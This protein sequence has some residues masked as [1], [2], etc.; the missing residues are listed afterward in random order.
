MFKNPFKKTLL[1]K[2]KEKLILLY[3]VFK[4]S[5]IDMIKQDGVEHSGYIAFLCLL[6][7]F[8]AVI[9]G[10]AIAGLVGG[11]E[12]GTSAI[13][14]FMSNV[15]ENMATSLKPIITE[16]I[17][18]PSQSILSIAFAGIIWTA[19]S[20]I[21]G[22]R[23]ILNRA[24]RVSS[25]PTYILR[26]LLSILHFLFFIAAIM[27]TIFAFVLIPILWGKINEILGLG[28][29]IN[30]SFLNNRYLILSLVLLLITSMAYYVIPNIKLKWKFILP[31]AFTTVI[32]WLISGKIFGIYLA[33]FSQFNLI[34]GSLGGIVIS[35]I[36]F[37]IMSMIFVWGAEFNYQFGTTFS[38]K[39]FVEK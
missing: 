38:K 8:P 16:I 3:K 13:N 39:S 29:T 6:S 5:T 20:E 31:G 22:L 17:S 11:S 27:A 35:L 14:A 37:Y 1:E 26:R 19:S 12:L 25:P 4:N 24:Y 36:F 32:G 15:P 34:Y 18:G 9:F 33:H 7:F 2:V 10:V 30:L 21:E 28:N 23:T